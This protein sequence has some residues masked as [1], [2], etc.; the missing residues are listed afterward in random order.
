MN[1]SRLVKKAKRG[2]KDALVQ[3]IMQEQL[4]FYKLAYTYVGNEHDALDMLEQ[5]I[6]IVYEKIQQLKDDEAFYSWSKTI[7]V[8]ECRALI[9]RKNRVTFLEDEIT[10]EQAVSP[11]DHIDNE[12]ELEQ[13]LAILS[14]VHKEAVQLKYLL[15]FD[16]ETIAE[17]TNVS[18]GTAKTRVFYALKKL[19]AHF[20]EES[21]HE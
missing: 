14:P 21:F 2:N 3:L 16:Y 18:V 5:M 7:L 8:N 9:K 11:I 4:Q 12:L 17:L 13:Y 1:V 20:G 10:P 6:V 15:D 19:R